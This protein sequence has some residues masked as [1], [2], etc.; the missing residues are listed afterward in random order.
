MAQHRIAVIPARGNSKGIP[1]KNLYPVAGRPLLWYTVRPALESGLFDAVVVSS[2]S[3]EILA[4]ASRLGA[5]PLRR[6]DEL[7]R[8]DV[9]AVHVVLDAVGALAPAPDAV[10][11]MLL[12][13]SP[14]R[15]AEDM[16]AAVAA[17]EAGDAD[18][19]V[20]V[21]RDVH[22]LLHFRT[23][24]DDGLLQPLVDGD[25]NVQRQDMPPLYVLN[26]SIY[27]SRAGTLLEHRSFHRGRV[28]PFVMDRHRSID[29]DR[30]DDIHDV[31]LRLVS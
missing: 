19:V 28:A 20:S 10:V 4:L 3:A 22:H 23:V 24:D 25:P 8:D 15:R 2:E 7:S 31:E 17:F 6:P 5:T 27:V 26:G 9:H 30:P 12:P 29:V 18:S 13:T 21:Y 16:A 11:T 14:L 1:G